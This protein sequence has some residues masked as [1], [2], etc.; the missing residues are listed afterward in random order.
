MT[1][2]EKDAGV[3]AVLLERFEKIRLPKAL[4]LKE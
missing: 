2:S 1:D 3:I 4:A